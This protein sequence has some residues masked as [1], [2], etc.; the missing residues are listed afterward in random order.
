MWG[1]HFKTEGTLREE[2]PSDSGN[3]REREREDVFGRKE[4]LGLSGRW[5]RCQ[6]YSVTEQQLCRRL[7]IPGFRR[8]CHY[9]CILRRKTKPVTHADLFCESFTSRFKAGE[10]RFRDAYF[11]KAHGT[12]FVYF[13]CVLRT[14]DGSACV[15]VRPESRCL[16][17]HLWILLVLRGKN[18]WKKTALHLN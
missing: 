9:Y 17:K 1:V 4:R 11:F 13:A 16:F 18:K 10:T 14:G 5:R 6:K 15:D 7:H 12:E 3:S 2:T 8:Q